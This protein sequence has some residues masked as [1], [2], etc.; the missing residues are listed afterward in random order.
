MSFEPPPPPAKSYTP[1]VSQTLYSYPPPSAPP[2]VNKPSTS[3]ETYYSQQPQSAYTYAQYPQ[4]P[5]YPPQQQTTAWVSAPY[6]PQVYPPPQL[7]QRYVVAM[8]PQQ[9]QQTSGMGPVGGF[10]AGMVVAN[11]LDEITDP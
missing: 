9:Q 8:P 6:Q 2:Q 4:Y 1:P 11:V 5:Q 10:L 3:P 7:Q